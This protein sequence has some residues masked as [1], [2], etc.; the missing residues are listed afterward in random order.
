MHPLHVSIP[1][2]CDDATL[3]A[4]FHR[5]LF[6]SKLDF[7]KYVLPREGRCCAP[8]DSRPRPLTTGCAVTT[9]MQEISYACEITTTA[10][11]TRNFGDLPPSILLGAQDMSGS[12]PSLCLPCIYVAAAVVGVPAIYTYASLLRLYVL[13][14]QYSE[15]NN[16]GAEKTNGSNCLDTHVKAIA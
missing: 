6:Y 14:L 11:Y 5:C 4:L 1:N 8:N 15:P 9:G 2:K 7:Y 3:F 16:I 12:F 10:E 13:L